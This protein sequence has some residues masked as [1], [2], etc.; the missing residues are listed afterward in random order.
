MGQEFGID[1]RTAGMAVEIREVRADA[2]QINKAINRPKQVIL[3]N[4]IL[5]REIVE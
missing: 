5:K 1:R 3:W 2:A 4:V